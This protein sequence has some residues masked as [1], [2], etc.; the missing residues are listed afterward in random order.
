MTEFNYDDPLALMPE[1]T[2]RALAA[3]HDYEA[4]GDGRSLSLLTKKYKEDK[5]AGQK[6]PSTNIQVM[7]QWSSRYHWQARLARLLE[8]RAAQREE[9][10]LQRLRE[11]EESDWQQGQVLREKVAALLVEMERFSTARVQDMVDADGEKIRVVTVKFKPTLSQMSMAAKIASELQR[12]SVG[13]STQ[14]NR[15]V[16]QAGEDLPIVGIEVVKPTP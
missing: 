12:L 4:M 7:T 6:P 13:A 9:L 1:E 8:I 15:L 3:F 5:A 2:V 11:L 14:N 10:R 16:N